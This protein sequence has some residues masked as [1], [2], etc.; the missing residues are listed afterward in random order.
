PALGQ[1]NVDVVTAGIREIVAD[2]IVTDDG[3]HHPADAIICGTGFQ[4]NDVGAPFD[5]TGIDGADLGAM[6]LRDGPQ[7]YLGTSIANFPNFFMM[8]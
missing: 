1:P 3:A 2:G 8:A 6:W 5:V 7:A 4:V